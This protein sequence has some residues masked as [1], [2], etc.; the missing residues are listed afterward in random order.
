M[1]GNIALTLYRL[2]FISLID[3]IFTTQCGDIIMIM[4]YKPLTLFV[5]NVFLDFMGFVLHYM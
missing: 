1:Y 4:M 3:G 5:L 2:E